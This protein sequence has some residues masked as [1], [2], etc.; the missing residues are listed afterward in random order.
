M[1]K[2]KCKVVLTKDPGWV[3]PETLE[4]AARRASETLEAYEI[5]VKSACRYMKEHNHRSRTD[6]LIRGSHKH[7]HYLA[8]NDAC[9]AAGVVIAEDC[10]PGWFGGYGYTITPVDQ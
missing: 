8:F 7:G 4:R 3:K 6:N 10:P 2:Y 9:K 1:K 5:T